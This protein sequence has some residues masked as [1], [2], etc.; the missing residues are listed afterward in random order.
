M[1]D[2]RSVHA[3]FFVD[4]SEKFGTTKQRTLEYVLLYVYGLVR[5]SQ[6]EGKCLLEQYFLFAK[7]SAAEFEIKQS[8]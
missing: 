5:W 1:L 3:N 6:K 2:E 4:D 7:L 8:N